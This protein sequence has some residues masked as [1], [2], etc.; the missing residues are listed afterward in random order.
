M[1]PHVMSG[2]VSYYHMIPHVMSCDVSC[3]FPQVFIK[4]ATHG[5]SMNSNRRMIITIL[6]VLWVWSAVSGCGLQ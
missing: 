5:K 6:Y 3:D 4:Q 1:I 2:D